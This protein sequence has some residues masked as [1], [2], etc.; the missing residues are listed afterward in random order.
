MTC[1]RS[2]SKCRAVTVV[3]VIT[4]AGAGVLAWGELLHWRASRRGLGTVD[5]GTGS[6]AVVVLG[7]R[8]A[9]DRANLINR[10][11]V[12][13]GIRSIDPRAPESVLVLCGGAVAGRISE[14]QIM[15]AE[16]RRRGYAG[17]ILLE[18]ESRTTRENIS[19]A[20]PLVENAARIAIVSDSMHAEFARGYLRE[21]RPDL[22]ARLVRGA[23]YRFGESILIKPIAALIAIRERRRTARRGAHRSPTS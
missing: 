4:A 1:R 12:R 23:D 8:N 20:V 9:G 3:G 2:E 7:Y 14:A 16:A 10:G 17:P 22:S 5:P 6:V 11:R 21:Q 19:G 15:A 18:T 13:A